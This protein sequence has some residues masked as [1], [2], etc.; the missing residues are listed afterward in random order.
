LKSKAD[1][2]P[3]LRRNF[4]YDFTDLNAEQLAA[5]NAIDGYIRVVAGAGTG[6]TRALTCRYVNLVENIGIPNENILCATFTNKAANEMKKRIKGMLGD[7]SPTRYITTFHGLGVKFFREEHNTIAFPKHFDNLDNEDRKFL[8]KIVFEKLKINTYELDKTIKKQLDNVSYAKTHCL[9]GYPEVFVSSSMDEITEGMRSSN[10][11]ERV[12]FSYLYEQ[13]KSFKLD[14]DDMIMVMLHVLKTNES[15][16]LKW[17]ER[18]QYV[19][20]DEFQDVSGTNYAVAEILS[21]M[22]KNLFIVGDPDQTIYSWRGAQVR[23]ILDFDKKFPSVKTLFLNANYRSTP[24]VVGASNALI[25]KNKHRIEKNL[26][27]FKSNG[28]PVLY[29]HSKSSED[30]AKYIANSIA[31]NVQNKGFKYSDFA[32]LYRAHFVSRTIEEVL[33][34]RKIPYRIYSGISFYERK[35]IKD[36]LSYMK[37]VLIDDDLAFRRVINEPSREVGAKTLKKIEDYAAANNCTLYKALK[38]IASSLDRPAVFPFIKMVEELRMNQDKMAVSDIFMELMN[39]S[40]YERM[41][42]VSGEEERLENLSELKDAI[43]TAEKDFGETFKL[44]DYFDIISLYTS[45]DGMD[46]RDN[47]KMMTIHAAKGLEFPIVFVAAMNEGVFP[48]S[49]IKKYS[50]LEEERRLAYVAMTRA[51]KGLVLTDSEGS[52]SNGY[53]YPSRFIFNID[54]SVIKYARELPKEL[55]DETMFFVKRDEQT[56]LSDISKFKVGDKVKHSLFGHGVV[57]LVKSDQYC[58]KF[59]NRIGNPPI[60][61]N[62]EHLTV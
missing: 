43:A 36:M 34:T 23:F 53:K 57:S 6:K 26:H 54:R 35:E 9:H 52:R 51:E 21:D 24:E 29:C 1:R 22:H 61:V 14:F 19:M 47:V 16:R 42:R 11:D 58:V 39:S 2:A 55:V 20:V 31:H 28:S 3:L 60:W 59:D 13:R 33:H 30:E 48:S 7:N 50:E 10:E 8:M 44:Q 56:L 4:M 27:A 38:E 18:M 49:R 12:F 17:Q 25:S 46:G 37:L 62:S 45:S 5:V 15:V 41:T 32:I 40:G